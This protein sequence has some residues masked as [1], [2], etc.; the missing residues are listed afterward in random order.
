MNNKNF[1]IQPPMESGTGLLL[2]SRTPES[3]SVCSDSEL[4]D[5]S[6]R[7]DG[8]VVLKQHLLGEVMVRLWL[9]QGDSEKLSA[10]REQLVNDLQ[11]GELVHHFTCRF[12]Y[13][14]EKPRTLSDQ[15]VS[16]W[17]N[18]ELIKGDTKTTWVYACRRLAAYLNCDGIIPAVVNGEAIAIPFTVNHRKHPRKFRD[19]N[20]TEIAGWIGESA[21]LWE[22][23]G[24]GFGVRLGCAFG[25]YARETWNG[26]H[27]VNGASFGLPV[28]LGACHRADD[29]PHPLEMICTGRIA[30][31]KL[32]KVDG[33]NAKLKLASKMGTRL[34][35]SPKNHESI[36]EREGL[37]H[38]RFEEETAC[39]DVLEQVLRAT[40]PD[41]DVSKALA[42]LFNRQ[43]RAFGRVIDEYCK[44]F[45][46]RT[47]QMSDITRW[48]LQLL[49]SNSAACQY[50]HGEPGCGKSA[51]M[52]NLAQQCHEHL[53][54][55]PSVFFFGK[56]LSSRDPDVV[57]TLARQLAQHVEFDWDTVSNETDSMEQFQAV[58]EH[59]ASEGIE[60]PLFVVDG[61]DEA[62][63][64]NL[65][66][67][68]TAIREHRQCIWILSGQSNL[69]DNIKEKIDGV[70]LFPLGRLLSDGMKKYVDHAAPEMPKQLKDAIVKKSEGLPLYTSVQLQT[71]HSIGDDL[72]VENLPG[73]NYWGPLF[74]RLMTPVD[75]SENPWRSLIPP[76]LAVFASARS[77][78][79]ISEELI[80]RVLTRMGRNCTSEMV[81]K[82]LHGAVA[83]VICEAQLENAAE[84]NNKLTRW[85]LRHGQFRQFIL[86]DAVFAGDRQAALN[87][88]EAIYRN[89]N[90]PG[91]CE[92][93][94]RYAA[95][96]VVPSLCESN[97]A[98][99][100]IELAKT[101]RF[102]EFQNAH[103]DTRLALDTLALGIKLAFDNSRLADVISLTIKR[104][105]WARE[106]YSE[107][108]IDA[109]RRFDES[110]ALEIVARIENQDDRTLWHLTL[111]AYHALGRRRKDAARI[112]DEHIPEGALR[113]KL[114]GG[115]SFCAAALLCILVDI[116]TE[117]FQWGWFLARLTDESKEFA[118]RTLIRLQLPDAAWAMI[119][120][121]KNPAKQ[122]D[123]RLA[124]V[125][126]LATDNT[127]LAERQL[128]RFLA[129]TKREW[130]TQEIVSAVAKQGDWTSVDRLLKQLRQPRQRAKA[131]GAVSA[132]L[133][134]Q[135]LLEK[136][137]RLLED[138]R[139][140]FAEAIT[141][142]DGCGLPEIKAMACAEFAMSQAEH[143]GFLEE[144]ERGFKRAFALLDDALRV[145]VHVVR[146]KFSKKKQA[147]AFVGL[148]GCLAAISPRF[149]NFRPLMEEAIERAFEA[150]EGT[151]TADERDRIRL[152]LLRLLGRWGH[153]KITTAILA[154]F[155]D[156]E[157]KRRG[158]AIL[159][160][161][162]LRHNP[163]TKALA[164][165]L[166]QARGHADRLEI[167]GL[168]ALE[169]VVTKPIEAVALLAE[170]LF[171]PRGNNAWRW[172]QPRILAQAALALLNHDNTAEG[173]FRSALAL[174]DKNLVEQ[175]RAWHFLDV[176][177]ASFS[178]GCDILGKEA[179]V[180]ARDER[181]FPTSEEQQI[182]VMA[183]IE[184]IE[185]KNGVRSMIEVENGGFF[186]RLWANRN[187]DLLYTFGLLRR[188]IGPFAESGREAELVQICQFVGER[189][190]RDAYK[191][192]AADRCVWAG[193][194]A[195]Q[196]AASVFHM[197]SLASWAD[198]FSDVCA[199]ISGD[200]ESGIEFPDVGRRALAVKTARGQFETGVRMA[201]KIGDGEQ[202][203]K[204]LRDIALDAVRRGEH[205]RIWALC[206]EMVN[207]RS[208]HLADIA[209][210]LAERA[211]MAHDSSEHF[212]DI[213]ACLAD[214]SKPADAAAV[215]LMRRLIV[216]CSDYPDAAFRTC[217]ALVRFFSPGKDDAL[218][219]L[220]AVESLIGRRLEDLRC[221]PGRT[222]R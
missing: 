43:R 156:Q 25:G 88:F 198:Q 5:L 32:H 73:L 163:N 112:L 135:G 70:I 114:S 104:A 167:A 6:S 206:N 17:S 81:Q 195:A 199:E 168:S 189:V 144:A 187:Q 219:I 9:Y 15:E 166:E 67:L 14:R 36:D 41:C 61:L 77:R 176:A 80:F 201:L 54:L 116:E 35:V 50:V 47:A 183:T 175:R 147:A 151:G 209:H 161:L 155:E 1:A 140:A 196:L 59:A 102:I 66:L 221:V 28:L 124:T 84:A 74:K 108:P 105:S 131:L 51:F 93:E 3:V 141:V 103:A 149:T 170:T 18:D 215:G 182:M 123:A 191:L 204:A 55:N 2:R 133:K 37:R 115:T 200:P 60:S 45:F 99:E 87:A 13:L 216:A 218:A 95:Q 86:D 174:I 122:D 146:R 208:E 181:N 57:E 12:K 150:L 92:E 184:G 145:P 94:K 192:D 179:L 127:F 42:P 26:K 4:R 159:S 106:Q 162:K 20:E 62:D 120:A 76:M 82:A 119:G 177:A 64:G 148:A 185:I 128:E 56:S 158:A 171:S 46:G 202:M 33:I 44:R 178:C 194:F 160:A 30:D 193:E 113:E 211:N 130:A 75:H 85:R 38:L 39:K 72:T 186:P 164:I 100:I 58:L 53:G 16:E 134:R 22:T 121:I 65:D 78:N 126:H 217:A 169:L 21:S 89:W 220:S 136:R 101:T 96:F 110:R 213:A 79:A 8:D 129:D 214:Q 154:K 111:A 40:N 212:A 142:I 90:D 29:S 23:L 63:I 172:G 117:H 153:V 190:R 11:A 31:K 10:A 109:L 98:N 19:W 132:E 157:A 222:T 83:V 49:G 107:T 197:P 27:L 97:S 52:V 7:S 205:A 71:W 188:V 210:L 24:F 69:N 68:F 139:R 165:L 34:F 173:K 91:L 138:G 152:R 203:S 48:L 207:D 143:G 180:H 137:Q 125:R 118:A